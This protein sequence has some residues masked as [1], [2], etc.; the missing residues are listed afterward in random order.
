M[1]SAVEERRGWALAM[2]GRARGD[3]PRYGTPEW[4]ALPDGPEK[5]AAVVRAAESFALECELFD[6]WLAAETKAAEDHAWRNA[7][8]RQRAA[9][10]A[11]RGRFRPDPTIAAEVAQDWRE[12]ARGEAS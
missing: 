5:V 9:W 7:R 6:E 8:D 1:V 2:M 3:Y 11:Q 10:D 12:W 4:L